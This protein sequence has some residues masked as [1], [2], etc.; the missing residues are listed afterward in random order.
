M[1]LEALQLQGGNESAGRERPWGS[2]VSRCG[3]HSGIHGRV[4]LL[5]LV[6]AL[7]RRR[8]VSVVSGWCGRCRVGG[9]GLLVQLLANDEGRGGGGHGLR[10]AN[11]RRVGRHVD[12]GGLAGRRAELLG[13]ADGRGEGGL[14]LGRARV[15]GRR[16]ALGIL[17]GSAEQA[18]ATER[19]GGRAPEG[20]DWRPG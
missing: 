15:L 16:S 20:G 7:R 14:D 19:R 17:R 1:P 2:G 4:L 10:M 13:R 11:L 6:V 3:I 18:E 8:S 5:P 9:M 12:V